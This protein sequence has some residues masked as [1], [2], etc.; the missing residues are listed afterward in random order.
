MTKREQEAMIKAI[1]EKYNELVGARIPCD[2]NDNIA[3]DSLSVQND[4]KGINVLNG[5]E[6]TTV[7]TGTLGK[8]QPGGYEEVNG[9]DGEE[10]EI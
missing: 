2:K 4:G 10:Q 9:K 1:E 6:A 7:L 8:V 5:I 3:I